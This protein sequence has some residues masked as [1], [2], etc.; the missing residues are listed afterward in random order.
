MQGLSEAHE[1]AL[2]EKGAS[3]VGFADLRDIPAD[4]RLGFPTGIS[5]VVPIDPEIVRRIG[6]GPTVEYYDECKRLNRLL[7][8][9]AEYT[10][11][12]IGQRGFKAHPQTTGNVLEDEATWST[13]LPHKTVATRAGLGWIGNC[14]LLVTEKYGSAVR[15]TSVLTDAD[16]PSGE[17][18][19]E[20]RC[21]DCTLCRDACPGKAVKGYNWAPGKDRDS[22][23]DPH[24]CRRTARSLMARFGIESSICGKCIYICPWT[25]KYINRGRK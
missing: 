3:M 2:L 1:K 12:F 9:L 21:G 13:P 7:D 6:N 8:S 22:F 5:I 24:S 14:A 10:A 25:Q 20:S 17:P 16:L 11:E 18:V 19:N 4:S 23:Y 15:I